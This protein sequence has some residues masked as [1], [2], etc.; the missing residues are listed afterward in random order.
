MGTI[1]IL[2]IIFNLL[3]KIIKPF[4]LN[5]IDKENERYEKE[6]GEE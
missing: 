6:K 3:W 1:I 2:L 4:M 5:E